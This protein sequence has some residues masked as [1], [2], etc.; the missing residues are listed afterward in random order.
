MMYILQR[1]ARSLIFLRFSNVCNDR[2]R[3]ACFN[4]PLKRL[5]N[6]KTG[7]FRNALSVNEAWFIDQSPHAKFVWNSSVINTLRKEQMVSRAILCNKSF[8][9]LRSGNMTSDDNGSNIS[10][11]EFCNISLHQ[12]FNINYFN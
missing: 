2:S 1:D 6:R 11:C 9:F 8:I 7:T 10:R 3:S 4:A 12:I 5:W